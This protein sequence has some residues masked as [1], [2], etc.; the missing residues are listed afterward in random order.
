VLTLRNEINQ[1]AGQI[2]RTACEDAVREDILVHARSLSQNGG[3][4]GQFPL[5][6]PKQYQQLVLD[7]LPQV[8]GRAA[9]NISHQFEQLLKRA[10]AQLETLEQDLGEAVNN[11]YRV[12]S[13]FLIPEPLS[14]GNTADEVQKFGRAGS[15]AR[16]R[17]LG[18]EVG[19]MWWHLFYSLSL[20][21]S[22][23][24]FL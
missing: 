19:R 8:S 9:R 13:T 14:G 3:N 21:L 12:K 24:L 17:K 11:L 16:T 22:L 1:D 5:T 2:V 4:G 23:A 20:S 15:K 7:S 18:I 10:I 6:S